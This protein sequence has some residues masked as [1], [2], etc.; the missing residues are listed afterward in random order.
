MVLEPV[1]F[2]LL[3]YSYYIEI[4]VCLTSLASVSIISGRLFEV[5]KFAWTSFHSYFSVQYVYKGI[6]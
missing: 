4:Q 2:G 1:T 5:Y 6:V 3:H